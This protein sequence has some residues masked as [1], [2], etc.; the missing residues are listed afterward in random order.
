MVVLLP[1]SSPF[2]LM[3]VAAVPRRWEKEKKGVGGGRGGGN[4]GG[5]AVERERRWN[6]AE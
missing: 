4:R 3:P 1:L 5:D 6:L 2:V